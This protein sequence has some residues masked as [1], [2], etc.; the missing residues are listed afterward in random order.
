MWLYQSVSPFE[1]ILCPLCWADGDKPSDQTIAK[2][3][4]GTLNKL[5]DILT[6]GSKKDMTSC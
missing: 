1:Y 2:S 5:G 6:Q 4:T 3:S